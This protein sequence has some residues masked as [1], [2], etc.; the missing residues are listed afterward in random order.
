MPRIGTASRWLGV[1]LLVFGLSIRP[2]KALPPQSEEEGPANKSEKSTKE[3]KKRANPALPRLVIE[4]GTGSP[5]VNVV[6]PL[7]QTPPQG[8][9]LRSLSVEIEWVSKNIQFVRLERG[10]SAESIGADVT[11]KITGTSKDAKSIEHST[12]RLD[13]S[14]VEENPTRGI[15][16]GLLAY[17]T[18]RISPEAQPFAIELR[19]KLISAEAIGSSGQKFT[20]AEAE[21]G[22][23]SVELPGLPPYVT[24]FFFTH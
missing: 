15:P 13:A 16:E 10:I 21:S 18:F 12:L 9:E 17:L 6:V 14:V 24:C 22:K 1:A 23:I 8:V 3:E 20:Q 7:Y 4:S 5:G 11:G 19:P 2:S